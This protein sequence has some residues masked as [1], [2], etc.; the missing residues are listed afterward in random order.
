MLSRLLLLSKTACRAHD[1]CSLLP[2]SMCSR[3][4][5]SGMVVVGVLSVEIVVVREVVESVETLR[6]KEV[7]VVD[8]VVGGVGNV[9]GNGVVVGDVVVGGVG[10]SGGK[11]VVV[12]GFGSRGRS[13]GIQNIYI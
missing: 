2:E 12:G 11:E 1:V 9:G 13:N 3:G 5:F 7:V 10:S 8:I 4:V 6:C